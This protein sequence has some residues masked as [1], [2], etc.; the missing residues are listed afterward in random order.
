M[1]SQQRIAVNTIAQYTRTLI[2]VCLSLYSTRLILAALGQ[3][4]YGIYSVVAGVV[5]MLSFMTNAL[6]TTTQRYLSF[7]HGQGDHERISHVFGNS[8][9]LHI[10]I[11]LGTVLVL[12]ALT[13]PVI[14]SLLNID[15]ARQTAAVTV[16]GAAV[17]ML[18]L[19]F[20]TAPFRALFIAREN[21]VYISVI[22]VVD[23]I[24]KLVIAILLSHVDSYDKLMTYAV[25]LTGISLFNLIAF[26]GYALTHYAECHL[27]R[28]REW[29]KQQIRDLSG[30][31]G[32]TIYSTG[33]IVA[34]TQGLAIILNRIF[35][36][37]INAAYGIAQQMIGAVLFV[38]QSVINAMNPQLIKA[39]GA[40]DRQRMLSFA[41]STSKYATLLMAMVV[42]PLVYEMPAILRIWLTVVPEHAVMF[43][44]FVLIASVCDQ[45]TIGLG[46]ANQ[47]IGKIRNYSLTVNTIK[48]LT[49]PAAWLCLYMGLPVEATMWCYVS[50]E[51]LCALTRLPF[52]RA[53]AGL[54]I[55]QF[56][57]NVFVRS[58]C[59]ILVMTAVCQAVMYW[60][61]SPYRLIVTL[62]ASTIAGVAAIWLTALTATEKETLKKI[63]LWKRNLD[64]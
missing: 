36:S 11:G 24:L 22:D 43:C 46:T 58:L 8:M 27:P 47:A 52:L 16:Y 5:A 6:V 31:A 9:L 4:D 59:P 57:V 7:Y 1:T 38:G 2:N 21:I 33:C 64:S 28:L 61:D 50:I 29:D 41:E 44:R 13:H 35:G 60:T 14:Y 40:G 17:I 30:F 18:L 25:L 63:V 15:E 55:G 42:I 39:E 3:T 48:V 54:N 51:L 53:T 26:A 34:R 32:W 56:V 12:G 19:T 45:L 10:L 62:A 23:G 20:L 49:L 37:A